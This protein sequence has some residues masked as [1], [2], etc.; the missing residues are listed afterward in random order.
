MLKNTSNLQNYFL[1][2]VYS[3]VQNI[4]KPKHAMN[5]RIV[6]MNPNEAIRHTFL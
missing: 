3:E 6:N 5:T 2:C 1:K 4:M